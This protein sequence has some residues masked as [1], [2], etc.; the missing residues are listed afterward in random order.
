[1]EDMVMPLLVLFGLDEDLLVQLLGVTQGTL[2]WA[3]TATR[4]E[5]PSAGSPEASSP[6]KKR[7]PRQQH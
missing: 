5:E 7:P 2:P 1:V 3:A 6:A 4:K